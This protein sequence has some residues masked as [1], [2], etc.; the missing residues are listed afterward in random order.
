MGSF[1]IKL[2]VD[3]LCLEIKDRNRPSIAEDFF[4]IGINKINLRMHPEFIFL[5]TP[6]ERSAINT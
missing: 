5:H 4:Q 6:S 1:F 2:T 3:L